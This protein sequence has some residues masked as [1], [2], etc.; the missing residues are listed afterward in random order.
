ML[1]HA[2]DFWI[3]GWCWLPAM[4]QEAEIPLKL[5][6]AFISPVTE[7]QTGMLYPGGISRNLGSGFLLMK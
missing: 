6:A 7:K 4:P 5:R 3:T 1:P 2:L